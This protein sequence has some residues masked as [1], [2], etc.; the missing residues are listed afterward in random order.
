MAPARRRPLL[1]VLPTAPLLA[2]CFA[3]GS[4]G[5]DGDGDGGDGGRLRVAMAFPPTEDF[6]PYGADATLLSRLGVTE[7]LS[8]LD[9]N[10]N[11]APALAESWTR[12]DDRT[13]LFTLRDARF[14]N[15]SPVTPNAVAE[16]LRQAGGAK[17]EP[18]ALTG[19][20]LGAEPAG[21]R[22]LRVTTADPDPVLPLRLSSPSLPVLAPDAYGEAGKADP[23]GTATGPFTLTETTGVARATLSRFDDYGD[24]RAQATGIDV[25]FTADGTA[26]TNAL[27]PGEVDIAEALP[28]S[29]AASLDGDAVRELDT[30][31]TTSL[32]LNTGSGPFAD[33][34]L[35][36]AAREAVDTGVLAEDV[37]EG[38]AE[39]GRGIFGSALVRAEA[40]RVEPSGRARPASPDGTALALATDDNRPELPEVAQVLQQQL[41]EAGFAVELEVREYSR[42]ESD[43]LAGEFDAFVSARNTMLDTGD[44]VSVLASDY[45]CDGGYNLALLCDRAVDEAVAAADAEDDVDKRRAAV[46]EAEAAALGTD[47]TVP[48]VHQ[49]ILHG[50][51]PDVQGVL[52]DPYERLL[53]GTGTRR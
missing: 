5:G 36:A 8:R 13:W 15:D 39:P 44:P 1:A 4:D 19:A 9:G 35:R 52:S 48:L 50:L 42:L 45:T 53:V 2:G 10:G 14:Q 27:R 22:Q 21:E 28:V 33:P 17:P 26:R 25:R 46:V 24:G 51:G 31:R 20:E 47:A 29:Q 43:V 32:L 41:Q 7:G 18:A 38:R 3:E 12:E 49:R 30:T 37:Y 16:A 34:G 11:A 6:S 23:R 40:D